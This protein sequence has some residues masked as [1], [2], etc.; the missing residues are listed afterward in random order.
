M[1]MFIPVASRRNSE[2]QGPPGWFSPEPGEGFIHSYGG[3]QCRSGKPGALVSISSALFVAGMTVFT[4]FIGDRVQPAA[5]A[6]DS[7]EWIAI[8]VCAMLVILMLVF[9]VRLKRK[10]LQAV[11]T[12][13]RMLFREKGRISA[14]RLADIARLEALDTNRGRCIGIH[15]RRQRGVAV[16]LPVPDEAAALAQISAMAQAAGAE[17]KQ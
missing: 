9:I 12:D 15:I 13:R 5:A 17:L 4:A 6:S 3:R 1:S 2:P 8:S 11:L 14:I 7:T 16:I 10:G